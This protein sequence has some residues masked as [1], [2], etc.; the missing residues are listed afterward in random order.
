VIIVRT[1]MRISYV[2]GGSDFSKH[3][4]SDFGSVTGTTINQYIYVYSKTLSEVAPE[5]IRFTY[6]QTE[7]V[8][9]VSSLQHP[10]LRATL[11]DLDWE[12]PINVGTFS[13]LPAGVG[14]GGSSAFTVGLLNMLNHRQGAHTD[15]RA[16]AKAAIR[17]ERDILEEYGGIQD[18]YHAAFGGFRNYR[19][20]N[21]GVVV[22]GLLLQED[23]INMLNKQQMLV[24]VDEP[25]NSSLQAQITA[26]HLSNGVSR[27]ISESAQVSEELFQRI[28]KTRDPR[29]QFRFLVKAVNDGWN[30]KMKYTS[31][32]SDAVKKII[33]LGFANGAAAAKLCGAGGSGFVLMLFEENQLESLKKAFENYKIIWPKIT[34]RGSEI[35]FKEIDET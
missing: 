16:L 32:T 18:Q 7:S 25:R 27:F 24:W 22:S 13:E 3:F 34:N 33:E 1:P 17:I 9:E 5:R 29:E 19:F 14:L 2:G 23:A 12:T 10:V 31:Q 11:Q 28:Q 8:N 4:N 21:K 20:S 6:R 30:L 26:Q 35:I 15:P